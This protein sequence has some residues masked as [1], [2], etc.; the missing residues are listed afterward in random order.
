M[1]P[2][3]AVYAPKHLAGDVAD[4]GSA[5]EPPQAAE[6]TEDEAPA[7]AAEELTVELN[8]EVRGKESAASGT[9]TAGKPDIG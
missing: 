6:N 3:T 9:A 1:S 2:K 7:P 5:E 8:A 4:N